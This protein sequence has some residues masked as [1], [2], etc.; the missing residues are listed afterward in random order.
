[1]GTKTDYVVLLTGTPSSRMQALNQEVAVMDLMM[2]MGK[3]VS[4][5]SAKSCNIYT[6]RNGCLANVKNGFRVDQKPFEGLI[7]DYDRI[8]WIDSDN[9][10]TTKDICRLLS[11]NEDIVAAWYRQYSAGEL[12]DKNKT[13]CGYWDR[14]NGYQRGSVR[15]L[16]IEDIPKQPVNNKGLIEVDYAGMGLMIVKKGV[17]ESMEYPWFRADIVRWEENGVQMAEIDT[18]DGGFCARA[19][20]KGF[21]VYI[22]PAVRILHEKIVGV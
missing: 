13:A 5:L 18:D 3:R 9:I 21:H 20:E 6:A 1:M 15:P 10:V 16:L 2:N 12:N 11:Y 8:I 14:K 19:Q 7:D 17:F 22:D 4:L